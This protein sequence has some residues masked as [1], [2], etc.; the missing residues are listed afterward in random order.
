MFT[1]WNK[2]LLYVKKCVFCQSIASAEPPFI[3]VSL[4]FTA[5]NLTSLFNSMVKSEHNLARAG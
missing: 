4:K 3:L 1:E 2:C 5:H